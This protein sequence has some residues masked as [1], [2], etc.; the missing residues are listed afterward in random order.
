MTA[1]VVIPTTSAPAQS[2]SVNLGGQNCRIELYT[3]SINV[4]AQSGPEFVAS[5]LVGI[6]YG[7]S[8]SGNSMVVSGSVVGD[9]PIGATVTGNGLPAGTTV[10][11]VP[12]G[13]MSR[14]GTYT[15][16]TAAAVTPQTRVTAYVSTLRPGNQILV[17][18]PPY[19]NTNPIFVDLYVSD[20]LVIGGVLL[21]NRNAVVRNSYLGF[22]GDIAV[23][24]TEGNSDPYGVPL[25]LPPADLMNSWQRD[26]PLA[27]GGNAPPNLAMT[28]PGMGSRFLLTY[29]PS[30]Q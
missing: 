29:W 11:A 20:A 6:G 19:E 21:Q 26:V 7:V 24:D 4:P 25:R 18:P 12:V 16:S 13:T 30:L 3:K 22:V 28:L 17:D 14:L 10:L 8:L 27:L 9:L 1:P 5:A 23:I 15:L 2:I